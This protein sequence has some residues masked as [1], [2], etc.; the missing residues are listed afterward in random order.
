MT[1]R[2]FSFE[3]VRNTMRKYEA[4]ATQVLMRKEIH[5]GYKPV[6][7]KYCQKRFG[8]PSNMA[9]Y[10]RLHAVGDTHEMTEGVFKSIDPLKYWVN[11]VANLDPE[12]VAAHKKNDTQKINEIISD[13]N[14]TTYDV[15]ICS[16][17]FHAFLLVV[18][19]E[20]DPTGYFP[21]MTSSDPFEIP[22]VM[23]CWRIELQYEEVAMQTYHITR[24]LLLFNGIKNS[25]KASFYIGR[26][27]KVKSVKCFDLACLRAAPRRYNA[28]LKDCVEFAKEFCT[29][30]LSYCENG[31]SLEK[32]VNSQLKEVTATGLS[33]EKLSRNSILSGIFGNVSLGGLNMSSFFSAGRTSA[34]AIILII[35]LLFIYP[36]FIA[37]IVIYFMK[38]QGY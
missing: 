25:I 24:K 13:G 8:D 16:D 11:D 14:P 35:F 6:R 1:G 7:C 23:A 19:A 4:T 2:S 29:C 28:I 20:E 30:L 34:V 9:R 22:D 36:I 5:T 32:H 17:G 10:I 33:L 12:I 21:N 27:V 31:C 18:G 15:F 37:I 26:Y 3:K 38:W